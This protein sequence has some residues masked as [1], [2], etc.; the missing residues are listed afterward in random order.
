MKKLEKY[1]DENMELFL[2]KLNLLF[3]FSHILELLGGSW[4]VKSKEKIINIRLRN[5]DQ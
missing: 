1:R 2:D 5:M 3:H 4:G